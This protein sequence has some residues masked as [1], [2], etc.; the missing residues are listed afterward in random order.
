MCGST[1]TLGALL[2]CSI[3]YLVDNV[4]P[5]LL[6]PGGCFRKVSAQIVDLIS[7]WWHLSSNFRYCSSV[8]CWSKSH[9][10]QFLFRFFCQLW[11]VRHSCKSFD[12]SKVRM[13]SWHAKIYITFLL[14]CEE[15]IYRQARTP[16]VKT[17]KSTCK[18]DPAPGHGE[19]L[20]EIL[21]IFWSLILPL[22]IKAMLS[23][24]RQNR[25][26]WGSRQLD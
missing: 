9:H 2:L 23:R 12:Q 8:T 26:T 10:I 13:L 7:P 11:F 17:S 14:W 6:L 25:N 5:Q 24:K 18:P 16:S 21:K 20:D 4:F 15:N 1:F 19:K 3:T 22:Y